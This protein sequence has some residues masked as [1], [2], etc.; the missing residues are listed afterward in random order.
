[1]DRVV[2]S[3][4]PQADGLDLER[5]NAKGHTALWEAV[6]S[7][8][9]P[10]VERL[11]AAG[12]KANVRDMGRKPL[13]VELIGKYGDDAL[14]LAL[15]ELLLKARLDPNMRDERGLSLLLKS[16]SLRADDWWVNEGSIRYMQL[17]TEHGADPGA[18]LA[19]RSAAQARQLIAAGANPD[20]ATDSRETA[21]ARALDMYGLSTLPINVGRPESVVLRERS[22]LLAIELVRSGASLDATDAQGRRAIDR[23][24]TNDPQL[25]DKLLQL[26][27]QRAEGTLSAEPTPAILERPITRFV[28]KG[29]GIPNSRNT[30]RGAWRG[31]LWFIDP[32]NGRAGPSYTRYRYIVTAYT[33]SSEEPW[34]TLIYE[35]DADSRRTVVYIPRPSE[36]WY[37]AGRMPAVP[38]AVA[39]QWYLVDPNWAREIL[40]VTSVRALMGP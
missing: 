7:L 21:L 10:G 36:S 14:A 33:D 12:A 20:Q 13:F 8:N 25:R 32:V 4:Q 28:L 5:R 29:P 40:S 16:M 35:W 23:D 24:R 30:I 9:R 26:A 2:R 3:P 18:L 1:M 17:L 37:P 34:Y 6:M 39:G 15:A 27:R 19:A 31:D 22:R 38:D 11:L